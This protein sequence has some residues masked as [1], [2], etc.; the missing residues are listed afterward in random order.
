MII[1]LIGLCFGDWFMVNALP[2][3]KFASHFVKKMWGGEKLGSLLGKA[4]PVGTG[5]SWDL[6]D[7][8]EFSSIVV[9]GCFAGQSLRDLIDQD[10]IALLGCCAEGKHFPLLYKYI[11]SNAMLSLQVHPG[12][13]WAVEHGTESKTEC[14]YIVAA[15]ADAFVYLGFKE[16]TSAKTL[17]ESLLAGDVERLL[18]KVFV[19]AGDFIFVPAGTVHCTGAGI[20]FAEIQ[21]NSD[22]TYR[23]SDWGRLDA[24]QLPRPLHV[25]R[26]LEVAHYQQQQEAVIKGQLLTDYDYDRRLMLSCDSFVVEKLCMGQ[27]VVD[28]LSIS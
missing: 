27:H 20:L 11:D 25:E 28:V 12:H 5:E 18:Q 7:R 24:Q 14:W 13:D 1:L 10:A 4:C 22:C 3:L 6:L 15:D 21:E 17:R 8:P 19:T 23:L 9:E 26:A 16:L 2:P